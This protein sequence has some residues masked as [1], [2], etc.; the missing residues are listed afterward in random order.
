M[1]LRSDVEALRD[2]AVAGLAA[3]HDHFVYTTKVWRIVDV[4]VRRRGRRIVLRNNVTGK[5]LTQLDLLAVGQSSIYEYLP[6]ATIQQFVSLTESFLTDLVRLWLTAYPA[7]LKG[8]V[9]VATVVSAP[10]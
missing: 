3:A 9:D 2:G 1:A 6:K 5:R 8:Q 4:E 7:H 10:D